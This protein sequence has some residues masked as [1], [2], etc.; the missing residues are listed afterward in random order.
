MAAF[1]KVK[2]LQVCISSCG[3]C[4]L[5]YVQHRVRMSRA[6]FD[7]AMGLMAT[8][9]CGLVSFCA[10]ELASSRFVRVRGDSLSSCALGTHSWHVKGSTGTQNI[11]PR[12]F[13]SV[14]LCFHQP[15]D[16]RRRSERPRSSYAT[17]SKPSQVFTHA[18]YKRVA[19]CTETSNSAI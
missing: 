15:C 19:G 6:F 11:S 2:S 9:T 8:G 13:L 12:C 7:N 14:A 17:P 18:E 10:I 4:C 5:R 1:P 16:L 3:C